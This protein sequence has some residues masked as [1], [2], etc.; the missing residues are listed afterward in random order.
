MISQVIFPFEAMFA[1]M[2]TPLVRTVENLVGPR[3]E[4]FAVTFEIVGPLGSVLAAGR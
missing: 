4:G 3:M 1:Y 2:S